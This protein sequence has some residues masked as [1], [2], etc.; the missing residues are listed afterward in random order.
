[1]DHDEEELCVCTVVSGSLC[2]GIL[3]NEPGTI[4]SSFFFVR[5]RR[6]L[7]S[8][9]S[10]FSSSIIVPALCMNFHTSLATSSALFVPRFF[11]SPST[12]FVCP[13]LLPGGTTSPSA[14]SSSVTSPDDRTIAPVSRDKINVLW[15]PGRF[16]SRAR[17]LAVSSD[18]EVCCIS[19]G[20]DYNRQGGG[21][22]VGMS[23]QLDAMSS[24]AV[25]KD[26]RSDRVSTCAMW[27]VRR[28]T[29]RSRIDRPSAS[30]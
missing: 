1:M 25:A 11:F 22:C 10:P 21:W 5:T 24:G 12:P 15:T 28:L 13:P 17:R 2:D 7:A 23:S 19:A 29:G 3:R 4:T 16:E 30:I 18:G 27:L 14:S 8:S 26:G 6:S 20:F 9:N